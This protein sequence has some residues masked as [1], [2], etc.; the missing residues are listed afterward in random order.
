MTSATGDNS[1]AILISA[2]DPSG[3][4]H[5][6]RLAEALRRRSGARCFGLGGERMRAAGVEIVADAS[7]VAVV[8]ISEVVRRL[9]AVWRAYR[10]LAAEA[11]RRRPALSILVDFPD[12]NLR[13]ARRLRASGLRVVYFISPQ[14]WA[15]R[16]GRVKLMKRLVERVLCIFPFEEKFYREAGVPADFVGHPLVDAVQPSATRAE[17]A[18]RHGLDAS[19]LIVAVLPGSRPGEIVHNLPGIRAACERIQKECACEFVLAAAPG[20]SEEALRA[21]DDSALNIRVVRGET[22]DALAAADC[23]IVSSGTA[24][25]EAALLGTPMV[26]VYRVSAATALI[27]RRLVSTPHFAMV[28]LIAG[29]R[30]VPE[31]IQDDFTPARVA[32]ETLRL[33]HSPQ[34]REAMR[35]QLA[36]VREKLGSGGAIERAAEIIAGMLSSA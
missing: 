7:Q 12:F 34:A 26:V 18:T 15:W 27:A 4:M 28:N 33:L 6:A 5:A 25:V 19:K 10:E 29:H 14:V 36:A 8:G 1:P 31:L 30:V 13:L 32:E 9:P 11:A 23:A 20:A 22:Y 17:F 35:Q 3:E 21:G 24:T 2:G 16:P